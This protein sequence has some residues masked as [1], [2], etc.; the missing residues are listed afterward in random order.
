MSILSP[1]LVVDTN[2][3]I[4]NCGGNEECYN[5]CIAD[6][7]PGQNN[8]HHHSRTEHHTSTYVPTSTAPWTSPL[9]TWTETNGPA[10]TTWYPS[11][12]C[13]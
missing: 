12:T 11:H 7:W 1:I 3:C 4:T 10:V 2:H 13:K 5:Q 6:H 9:P 8:G